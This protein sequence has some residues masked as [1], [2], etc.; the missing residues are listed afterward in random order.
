MT[1]PENGDVPEV[2]RHDR[3]QITAHCIGAVAGP[4]TQQATK[5]PR[6]LAAIMATGA[7]AWL[8]VRVRLSA[9][10]SIHRPAATEHRMVPVMRRA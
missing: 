5:V 8:Q 6:W 7:F 4:E 10:R 1:E 2:P 9:H 3:D